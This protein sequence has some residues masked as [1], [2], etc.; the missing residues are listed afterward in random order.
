MSRCGCPPDIRSRVRGTRRPAHT[1]AQIATVA[2]IEVMNP[3]L[4]LCHLDEGA[5]T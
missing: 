4:V 2:D 5:G 3:D 1:A